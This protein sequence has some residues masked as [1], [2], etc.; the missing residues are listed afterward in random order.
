LHKGALR[1]PRVFSFCRLS[2][3]GGYIF[4]EGCVAGREELVLLRFVD[5][6]DKVPCGVAERVELWVLE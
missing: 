1:E 6:G 5:G 2:E 4:P 3:L